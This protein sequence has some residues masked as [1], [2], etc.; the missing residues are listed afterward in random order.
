M[1]RDGERNVLGSWKMRLREGLYG[2]SKME[3]ELNFFNFFFSFKP[4]YHPFRSL[5]WH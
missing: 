4:M 3:L 5:N 1:V 2:K